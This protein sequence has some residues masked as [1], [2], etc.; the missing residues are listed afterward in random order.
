MTTAQHLGDS[1]ALQDI[2][3]RVARGSQ[4]A[5]QGQ[6]AT[7]H[8]RAVVFG[9]KL[10]R[11]TIESEPVASRCDATSTSILLQYEIMCFVEGKSK[12]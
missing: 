2:K 3:R 9:E 6:P 5:T 8:Q 12:R 10:L 1:P 11:V 4:S 7:V